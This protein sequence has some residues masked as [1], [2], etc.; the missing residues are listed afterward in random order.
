MARRTAGRTAPRERDAR[1]R[2]GSSALSRSVV[3]ALSALCFGYCAADTEFSILEEA[4][5]LSEQMKKL[6]SQELGV[7]TMQV[8]EPSLNAP[9]P[10]L[11]PNLR[12][13]DRRTAAAMEAGTSTRWGN[14]CWCFSQ[15]SAPGSSG[16][17]LKLGRRGLSLQTASSP[18]L[19]LPPPRACSRRNKPSR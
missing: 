18:P 6:S 8:S 13:C 9:N 12:V 10:Q 11:Q 4:R 14:F 2:G 17:S 3:F 1:P 15:H 7:F 5:V 16:S 19:S